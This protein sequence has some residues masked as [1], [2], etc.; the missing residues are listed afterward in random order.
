MPTPTVNEM[1]PA[2]TLTVGVA[3]FLFGV[4]IVAGVVTVHG[5]NEGFSYSLLSLSVVLMVIGGW[6]LRKMQLT[7]LTA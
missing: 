6:R 1:K 7:P 4:S 3:L 5:V 2:V